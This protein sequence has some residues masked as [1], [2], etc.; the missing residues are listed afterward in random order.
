MKK[1]FL[2][3]FDNFLKVGLILGSIWLGKDFLIA[4]SE[5]DYGL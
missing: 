2:R 5:N 3:W 4:F 1:M